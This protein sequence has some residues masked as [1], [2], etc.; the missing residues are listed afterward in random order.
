MA[1]TINRP[2]LKKA[3]GVLGMASLGA[4][5]MARRGNGSTSVDEVASGDAD[6]ND[7]AQADVI[8]RYRTALEQAMWGGDTDRRD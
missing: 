3:L 2:W 1:F 6:D 7:D 8:A 5:L 4:L